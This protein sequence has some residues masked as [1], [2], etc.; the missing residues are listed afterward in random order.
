[1]LVATRTYGLMKRARI[2]AV[3]AGCAFA[4]GLAP[5]PAQAEGF[6]EALFGGLHRAVRSVT[7]APKA[8]VAPIESLGD[9]MGNALGDGRALPPQSEAGM[10]G[11]AY[12]V[13]LCDGR[14]FPIQ[15]HI[16]D[17]DL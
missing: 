14:Y 4:I 7:Q 8:V 13:R 2:A 15:R 11:P 1:M 5:A 17:F 3:A 12:C 9:A 6:F 16:H 10:R